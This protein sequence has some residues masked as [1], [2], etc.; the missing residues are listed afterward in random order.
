M[1]V[2]FSLVKALRQMYIKMIDL[3][4]LKNILI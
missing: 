4:Q 1:A 2:L 3:A